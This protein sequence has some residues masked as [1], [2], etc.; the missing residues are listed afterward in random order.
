MTNQFMPY[1]LSLMQTAQLVAR[2]Q[3]NLIVTTITNNPVF[4]VTSIVFPIVPSPSLPPAFPPSIHRISD[5]FPDG[6]IE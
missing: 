6:W 5:R 4:C 2:Q 1:S 3:N